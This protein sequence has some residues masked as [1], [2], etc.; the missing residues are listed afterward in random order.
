MPDGFIVGNR[1]TTLLFA[2]G[3]IEDGPL[4]SGMVGWQT[5][6]DPKN[7]CVR[8]SEK[9]KKAVPS[10]TTNLPGTAIFARF[11]FARTGVF[12]VP[13]DLLASAHN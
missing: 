11:I 5:P 10:G 1:A 9:E 13:A 2:S 4:G 7:S 6:N 12:P 3:I 8:I